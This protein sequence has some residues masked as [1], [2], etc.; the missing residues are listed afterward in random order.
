MKTALIFIADGFEEAEALV[1]ADALARAGFKVTLA[2]VG[3]LERK[4][5]HGIK[6]TC[7]MLSEDVKD[8]YDIIYLPGGMPGALNLHSSKAV[9]DAIKKQFESGRIVSA[10]CASPAAV[11]GPAG[12]LF[13]KKATCY[14][15]CESFHSGFKFSSEKVVVDG[16]VVTAKAAGAAWD[17]AL[18]LIEMTLGKVKAEEVR[19]SIYYL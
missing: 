5:S 16:N 17:V 19:S 7:D 1:P 11:L 3:G 15:G 6:V 14:P 4:G 9:N 2:G 18:K 13:G 8:G 12:I 10:I